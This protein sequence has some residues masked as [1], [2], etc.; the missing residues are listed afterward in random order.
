MEVLK[1]T[2]M[3]ARWIP[4]LYVLAA[5]VG[6]FCFIALCFILRKALEGLFN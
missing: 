4:V 1:Q 3:A 6:I 2:F 5:V